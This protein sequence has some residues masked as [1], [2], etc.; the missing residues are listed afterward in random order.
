VVTKVLPPCRSSEFR[1]SYVLRNTQANL[2][3][4]IHGHKAYTGKKEAYTVARTSIRFMQ[5]ELKVN[6][7][8]QMY[9]PALWSLLRHCWVRFSV[10]PLSLAD[11]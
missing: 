10:V 3:E 2:I 5:T 8:L 4:G 7:A 6:I 1:T 11:R 9:V